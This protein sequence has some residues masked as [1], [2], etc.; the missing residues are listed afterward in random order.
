MSLPVTL[1]QVDLIDDEVQSYI[2]D[3]LMM[4]LKSDGS[5]STVVMLLLTA[6][7]TS[8]KRLNLSTPHKSGVGKR[9][10]ASTPKTRTVSSQRGRGRRG[11][12]AHSQTPLSGRST[13]S[14]QLVTNSA[15]ETSQ[16]R[17]RFTFLMLLVVLCITLCKHLSLF[18]KPLRVVTD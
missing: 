14:E 16:F 3:D 1:W 2:C 12:V 11:R 4:W 7:S 10:A 18:D 9:T 5:L 6:A 15:A 13:G 8:K 17:G